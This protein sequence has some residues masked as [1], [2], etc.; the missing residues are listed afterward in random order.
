M[1]LQEL[2]HTLEVEAPAVEV[3][4][5][6]LGTIEEAGPTELTFL[7]NDRYTAR[8]ATSRAG[9]ALVPT[10][11]AGEAPM[12]LL[13]TDQ[14]RIAFARAL[15]IFH[16]VHKP[17][18]GVHP[19][20]LV[21]ESCEL[22]ADV[23]VGAYVV[24]GEGVRVGARSVLHPHCV[25]YDGVTLGA[26]CEIHSHA[27]LREGIVLGDR[28]VVQNGCVIGADGFGFE[29]DAQGRLQRVPQV[30]TVR[31]GDDVDVQANACID[32]SALGATRI[33][34]GTKIDNLAQI[35]HGCVVGEDTVLCGQVGLAGSTVVG[36]RVMLG[37]Q[38]GSSGHIQIGDGTR[39]AAQS[40]IITDLPAGEEFGGTPAMPLKRA[41][42]AALFLGE[43]PDMARRIKK[44][45][46]ALEKRAP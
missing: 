44:L 25:L 46:R 11:F 40:G 24:L 16:P 27:S 23:H 2:A 14:P 6:G 18:P 20:A 1:S 21:P 39:V 13:R 35:A 32:R 30:G 9:A 4:I 17:A 34:R 36:S 22:G 12:P 10:D 41:L 37:G 26:D 31:L 43:L 7:S 29:P 19:T 15:E 3:E 8:L 42:R 38:V 28:V 45:E 33:G 5:T